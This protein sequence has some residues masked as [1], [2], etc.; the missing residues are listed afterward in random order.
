MSMPIEETPWKDQS[1]AEKIGTVIF[2]S[3]MFSI[4]F[5]VLGSMVWLSPVIGGG[6]VLV[7]LLLVL[8]FALK[9]GRG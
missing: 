9:F 1:L 7:L 4:L 6:L 2:N 3:L 5:F 8:S